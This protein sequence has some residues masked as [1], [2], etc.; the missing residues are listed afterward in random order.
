MKQHVFDRI[1]TLGLS[2][3]DKKITIHNADDHNVVVTEGI[4][5]IIWEGFL[6]RLAD[7]C[8]ANCCTYVCIETRADHKSVSIRGATFA[9][10]HCED[11][12]I[13]IMHIGTNEE[14]DRIDNAARPTSREVQCH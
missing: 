7:L 9:T 11:R 4:Y 5:R 3:A 8:N 12:N 1:F 2:D 14:V 6:L 13:V 10:C